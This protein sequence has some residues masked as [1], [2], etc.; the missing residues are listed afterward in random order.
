[1]IIRELNT[2]RRDVAVVLEYD[3]LRCLDNALYQL[4]K[5]EDAEK[6]DNF[7]VVR[8]QIKELWDLVK[9]GMITDSSLRLIHRLIFQGDLDDVKAEWVDGVYE[10][11]NHTGLAIYKATCSNCGHRCEINSLCPKCGSVMRKPID[12]NSVTSKSQRGD[13]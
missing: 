12:C 3:E 7:N 10:P 1:M 11:D 6:D 4:S 13:L 9:H 2:S 5:I 8:A